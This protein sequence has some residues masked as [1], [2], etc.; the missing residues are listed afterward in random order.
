MF[1]SFY[2][3]VT[4]R[5]GEGEGRENNITYCIKHCLTWN[6]DLLK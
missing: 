2:N 5:D 3:E 1:G 4:T 6:R